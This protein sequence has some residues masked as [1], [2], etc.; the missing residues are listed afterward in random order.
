[1]DPLLLQPEMK[2]ALDGPRYRAE[3]P[4]LPIISYLLGRGKT[5]L[6]LQVYAIVN[7]VFWYLLLVGLLSYTKAQ[8]LRDYLCISA[9][10]LGYG[11]L[12]SILRALTDLPAATIGFYG[13]TM[14]GLMGSVLI[15]C[16][17]LTKP[18]SLLFALPHL[19]AA[20]SV[21]LRYLYRWAIV[22]LI[23][24]AWM[25][26]IIWAL[27]PSKPGPGNFSWP[28]LGLAHQVGIFFERVMVFPVRYSI[29]LEFLTVL[30]DLACLLSLLVQVVY[31]VFQRN[32]GCRWWW[33]GAGF[34]VLYLFLN[35]SVLEEPIA[36]ARAVIPLTL[37][38]NLCL[39]NET[40]GVF[41]LYFFWGN[42]GLTWIWLRPTLDLIPF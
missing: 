1:L 42:I 16:A 7:F 28:G 5:T 33:L 27:P 34:S 17:I 40:P 31:F 15:A 20:F 41:R 39:R 37:A 4:V 12:M 2:V 35:H 22:V 26:Y 23:P 24:A 6:V 14:E 13:L 38:F 11:V 30:F 19:G 29:I 18:S 8:S 36:F 3:R 32:F 10:M 21:S 9:I 25:L